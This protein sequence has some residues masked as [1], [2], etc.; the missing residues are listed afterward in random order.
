VDSGPTA[1]LLQ[2][3]Q[4]VLLIVLQGEEGNGRY[5]VV[6]VIATEEGK[7]RLSGRQRG[8]GK[9]RGRERGRERIV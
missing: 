1:H 8:C 2:A 9:E 3:E 4:V 6:S 7:N 5:P